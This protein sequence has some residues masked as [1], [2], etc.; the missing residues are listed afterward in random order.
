VIAEYDNGAAVNS[1]SR[2]YIYGGGT[3][4][5]KIDSTGTKYYHQDHLSNRLVTSSAG[6]TLEQMGHFPF[7]DPWYNAANDKLYFTT[8]ERDAESG[9]DYAMARYY[10]WRIGRFLSLDPLSGST[11]DPQS[12][13]RYDYTE[14]DP[15]DKTDPSGQCI[16]PGSPLLNG[17]HQGFQCPPNTMGSDVGFGGGGWSDASNGFWDALIAGDVATFGPSGQYGFS[18]DN[19]NSPMYGS[20][21]NYTLAPWAILGDIYTNLTGQQ[22][23]IEGDNG[24]GDLMQTGG[25]NGPPSSPQGPKSDQDCLKAK[26]KAAI[27]GANFNNASTTSHNGHLQQG[28]TAPLDQITSALQPFNPLG[29]N[30]GY[31]GSTVLFALHVNGVTSSVPNSNN[32]QAEGHVDVL[33]PSTGLFGA[34]GHLAVDLG[35]GRLAF[36]NSSALDPKCK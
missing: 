4:L 18:Q 30:N 33:N 12:L 8:Y 5:A 15:I 20:I 21:G 1:P 24:S 10:T 3:L 16:P 29:I 7:G 26:I 34:L 23:G 22:F 36:H 35:L 32:A 14:N 2:E 11:S 6:T 25:P 31:R 28:F 9:N 27:P 13:N 17:V 19:W